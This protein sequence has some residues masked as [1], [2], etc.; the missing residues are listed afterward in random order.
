MS[1]KPNIPTHIHMYV[2]MG[3]GVIVSQTRDYIVDAFLHLVYKQYV[4]EIPPDHLGYLYSF[5][6]HWQYASPW[7]GLQ[8]PI[9]YH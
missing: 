9:L 8:S 2:W 3:G 7:C 5:H 1:G 6:F 4:E